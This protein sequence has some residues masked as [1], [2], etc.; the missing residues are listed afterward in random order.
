MGP[1]P[2][3]G[4]RDAVRADVLQ[5]TALP[6]QALHPQAAQCGHDL[7]DHRALRRRDNECPERLQRYRQ[8]VVFGERLGIV[9]ITDLSGDRRAAIARDRPQRTGPEHGCRS[10]EHEDHPAT[11]LDLGGVAHV[12]VT[13]HLTEDSGA[14]FAIEQAATGHQ[15]TITGETGDAGLEK[16]SIQCRVRVNDHDD[17]VVALVGQ[18]TRQNL[19]QGARLLLGVGHRLIDFDSM[20]QRHGHSAIG[21]VVGDDNAAFGS[22]GLRQER[23]ESGR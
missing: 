6:A 21:A 19:V 10:R 8:L 22:V 13:L 11:A 17:V 16:A 20:F 1:I 7:G 23:A 14:R 9:H 12:L 3:G 2:K 5:G 15:R 18:D 4:R